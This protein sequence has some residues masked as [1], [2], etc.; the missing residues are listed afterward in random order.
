MT[1]LIFLPDED[2]VSVLEASL[3]PEELAAAVNS[4]QWRPPEPYGLLLKNLIQ[5]NGAVPLRALVFAG[6]VVVALQPTHD[7]LLESEIAKEAASL[8]RRQRQ[9]LQGMAEGLTDDQVALRLGLTRRTVSTHASRLKKRL[10]ATSRAQVVGIAAALGMLDGHTEL[11]SLPD[12][13][14]D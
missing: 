14:D 10:G 4:G 11:Q 3:P 13:R 5:A 12:T 7:L 6:A 1:R 2:T 8:S 9:V